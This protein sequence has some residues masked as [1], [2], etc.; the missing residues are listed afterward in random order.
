MALLQPLKYHYFGEKST[1]SL[2]VFI[3]AID[4]AV[5]GNLVLK[6]IWVGHGRT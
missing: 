2:E 3:L 4:M 5:C 6:P 1:N